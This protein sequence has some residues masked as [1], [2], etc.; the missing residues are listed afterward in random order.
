MIRIFV[1]VKIWLLLLALLPGVA[2]P[3]GAI[4]VTPEEML[5]DPALEARAREISKTL[6]CLVCQN[7]SID[8]SDADLAR[9]LRLEV[10]QRLTDGDSDAAILQAI[11][12]TYGD[13]VL[14]NPPVSPATL[15]LWV[16]PVIILVGGAL[17]VV[18]ARRRRDPDDADP[19]HAAPASE[20]VTANPGVPVTLALVL[21]SLALGCSLLIY[22]M[23]GR[24]DL[25]DRPLAERT[26]EIAATRN[27]T[28]EDN[29]ARLN[30]LDRARA[31]VTA[32]PDDVGNWLAL[33]VAAANAGRTESEVTALRQAMN[34]TD[35]DPAITA[36]LAEAL[37]R[38]ADGQVTIPARDLIA[39]ALARNPQEPRALFLAGLAAYQDEEFA[40]AV[41]TWQALQVI[42]RPDAPWM[43]LLAEN[44]ANAAAAGDIDL[45]ASPPADADPESAGPTAADIASAAEMSDEDRNAM[46][47]GMVESL[48]SRLEDNPDDGAGWQRLAR[49]YEVLD[50]PADAQDA[51]IRAADALADDADA[52]LQALQAIVM[53]D[54]ESQ[55]QEAATRVMT[56]LSALAPDRPETLY[57]QGHFAASNGDAKA[58]RQFWQDLLSRLPAD[59][60]I[61]DQLRA[62][63]DAL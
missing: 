17:L 25:P 57:L 15:I 60:P 58:A 11:R 2:M 31:D 44:I 34:L 54:A 63:I 51:Y 56:R 26:A 35:G 48:A 55:L 38:A 20:Q 13:Y 32:N 41:A 36:M 5:A 4:A 16:A 3:A 14:L 8:D 42:S 53:G 45:A 7:Q 22:L 21:F 6:R 61:A 33:A 37:S 24:A 49:A 59:A 46:I 10:R 29:A 28:A 18:M 43:P 40:T 19:D 30:A 23:L 27:S 50:R 39:A 1:P 62:A 52:Q 9:D 12:E 47:A